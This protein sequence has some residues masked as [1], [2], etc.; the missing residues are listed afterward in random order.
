MAMPMFLLWLMSIPILALGAI[1]VRRKKDNLL[2][3]ALGTATIA[4]SCS[5]LGLG[6]L[7]LAAMF[8]LS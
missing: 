3:L 1:I 7:M 5:F 4:L 2:F 8:A 6:A